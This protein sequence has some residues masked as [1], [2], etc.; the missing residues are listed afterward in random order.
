MNK[1]HNLDKK[2]KKKIVRDKE[3]KISIE[4]EKDKE[5][6][7]DRKI[8]IYKN[9]DKEIDKDKE[10]VKDLVNYNNSPQAAICNAMIVVVVLVHHNVTVNGNNVSKFFNKNRRFRFDSPPKSD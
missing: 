6:K 10:V 4:I 5:K 1:G 9:K 2:E 8:E 7:K 3:K